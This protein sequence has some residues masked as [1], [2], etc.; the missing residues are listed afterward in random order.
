MAN[1][2]RD[3]CEHANREAKKVAAILLSKPDE[4][5]AERSAEQLMAAIE[6]ER[7]EEGR[8]L[9]A[10]V[11]QATEDIA[12]AKN[13]VHGYEER[14]AA[15]ERS[16][17]DEQKR[18]VEEKKNRDTVLRELREFVNRAPALLQDIGEAR[19]AVAAARKKKNELV[20]RERELKE[21]LDKP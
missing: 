1:R 4:D 5:L 9:Q 11:R 19:R 21:E 14:Y 20:L 16:I 8:T 17:R 3:Q 15:A 12:A 18:E 10:L 7:E 6:A 2:F 13:R